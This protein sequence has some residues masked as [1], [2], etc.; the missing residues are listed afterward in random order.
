MNF[1]SWLRA[2]LRADIKAGRRD[3]DTAPATFSLSEVEELE[4]AHAR[5]IDR[6]RARRQGAFDAERARWM[7]R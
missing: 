5:Q 7:Q 3:L 2:E 6:F 1:E 4:S